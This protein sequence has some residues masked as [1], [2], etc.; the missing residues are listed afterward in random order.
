MSQIQGP[1]FSAQAAHHSNLG[2]RTN[3][4]VSG[5]SRSSCRE[6]ADLVGVDRGTPE[7]KEKGGGVTGSTCMGERRQRTRA[8]TGGGVGGDGKGRGEGRRG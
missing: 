6:R 3:W 5:K 8:M 4:W 2:T 7:G 1:P